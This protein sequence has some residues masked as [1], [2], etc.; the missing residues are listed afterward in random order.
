MN[1]RLS[2]AA[3]WILVQRILEKLLD[4]VTADQ[5]LSI[6]GDLVALVIPKLE[7]HHFVEFGDKIASMDADRFGLDDE[8]ANL[9]YRMG[10]RPDKAIAAGPVI[11]VND[12]SLEPKVIIGTPAAT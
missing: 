1:L 10:G 2:S 6:L 11:E 3:A 9:M 7:K 8:F 5:A 4:Q 12:E